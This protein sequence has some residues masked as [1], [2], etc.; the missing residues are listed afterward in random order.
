MGHARQRRVLG[1]L[2]VDVGRVVPADVLVERVWGELMPRRGREA[3]YGYV[4]RLRQALTSVGADI[5]REQGGYRLAVDGEAVDLYR[6]RGLAGQAR[7]AGA[8]ERAVALWEEALGLWRGEAFAGADTPWFNA[9]R[10]LLDAERLA[11]QLDL[12]EVRLQLGQHPRILAECSAR[13]EAYPLD[14][15]VA[16]QFMLALY[17]CG[18][19]AEAL[20]CYERV[21]HGLAEEMGVDPGAP[22]RQ[23]HQQILTADTA[24][25][26]PVPRSASAAAPGLSPAPVSRPAVVPRELPPTAGTFVGREDLLTELGALLDDGNRD[27]DAAPVPV[28]TGAA[29]IGKTTFVLHCA[30]RLANCFPDGQLYLDLHGFSPGTAPLSPRQALERLLRSLGVA[31]EELPGTAEEQSALLRTLLADRRVLVVLDNAAG[32]EQVRPLLQGSRRCRVVVTSRQALRGLLVTHEVYTFV[33]DL[34]TPQQARELLERLL[35]ARRAAGA[36]D[37]LAE[38]ARLCGYLPLA[39]RLA[40]AHLV[41]R[42]Q[43]GLEEFVAR[44]RREGRL[45]VLAVEDDLHAGVRAALE[46]SYGGLPA[47]TRRTFLLAGL[48]PGQEFGTA[49]VAVLAGRSVRE[50]DEELDRLAGLHMVEQTRADRWRMHDLLREFAG[51]RLRQ[52]STAQ[53]REAAGREL[54]DWYAAACEAAMDLVDPHRRRLPSPAVAVG[55][56]RPP[57]FASAGEATAWLETECTNLVGTIRLCARHGWHDRTVRLAHALWRHLLFTRRTGDWVATHELALEAA[58]AAGDVRAEAEM[59]TNLATARMV[60]GDGAEG[61]ALYEHALTLRRACGDRPGEAATRGNLGNAYYLSGRYD[62]AAACY[63]SAL[64]LFRDLDDTRGQAN[65]LNSLG[66]LAAL[67]GQAPRAQTAY[68]ESLALFRKIGDSHGEAN[69]MVNLGA[70]LSEHGSP[71][72]ARAHLEQALPLF[73]RLGDPAGQAETLS[74][75]GRLTIQ[76][77]AAADALPHLTQALELSRRAQDQA[78]EAETLVHLGEAH[79]ATG[80][81]HAAREAWQQALGILARIGHPDAELNRIRTLLHALDPDSPTPADP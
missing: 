64:E 60:T 28:V 22:L 12:A 58:R 30:H 45:S 24:I 79:R 65:T 32:A 23:L 21:R 76:E 46:L 72:D 36:G 42:P 39:L 78:L 4:S 49:A 81:P 43:L 50:A 57:S 27:P 33:L 15:R 11:A 25:A 68:E 1:A 37:V 34:L 74:K 26:A 8:E 10:A 2:L 14:E 3:L 59:L 52:E 63:H 66:R 40:A 61:T 20:E 56:A 53:E 7:E 13:A 55:A 29:G 41:S 54:V 80:T 77:N 73:Q 70:L 67:H 19:Q 16:G 18:R 62:D 9:Q 31:A 75:L 6:F 69:I 71:T 47:P 48:H 51:A 5:V 44:L 35:G 38:L 17:R